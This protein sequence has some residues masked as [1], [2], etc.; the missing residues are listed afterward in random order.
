MTEL[1]EE[2]GP[3]ALELIEE[4]GKGIFVD[5]MPIGSYD[6][7]TATNTVIATTIETKAI[8]ED[9]K[10]GQTVNG[11]L[12]ELGD[13]KLTVAALPFERKPT[14]QDKVRFKVAPLVEWTV[15]SVIEV[16][17]GERA[18]IYELQVRGGA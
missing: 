3:L 1:D 14:S 7:A 15:I 6:V 13:K 18:A 12:V 5:T 2:L 4:F 10:L 17:S 9:F 8:E 16:M 11:G